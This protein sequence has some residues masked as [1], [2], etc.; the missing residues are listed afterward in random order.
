ML[1]GKADQASKYSG[2]AV[3]T[4]IAGEP[5]IAKNQA[6][7]IFD[8]LIALIIGFLLATFIALLKENDNWD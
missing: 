2:N 3:F 6:N 4:I 8:G 1:Q 5:I 7:F